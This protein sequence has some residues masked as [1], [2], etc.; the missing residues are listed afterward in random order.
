M[1]RQV[2]D[3]DVDAI[4]RIYNHYVIEST[5]TFE[6][7]AVSPAEMLRRIA[8]TASAALPW[9]VAERIGDV[10]GYAARRRQS[11]AA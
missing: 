3:A 11:L 1:I 9:L 5:I 2:V 6:E 10:K 8:D 7:Q 4:C